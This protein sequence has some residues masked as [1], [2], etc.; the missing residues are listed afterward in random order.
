M[1]GNSRQLASNN[2]TRAIWSVILFK[3]FQPSEVVSHSL[4]QVFSMWGFLF[5]CLFFHFWEHLKG[6]VQIINGI[7]HSFCPS[8]GSPFILPIFTVKATTTRTFFISVEHFQT[9]RQAFFKNKV[10]LW[11]KASTTKRDRNQ[12]RKGVSAPYPSHLQCNKQWHGETVRK[13]PPVQVKFARRNRN[14]RLLT[15]IC[16]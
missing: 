15:T 8:Q 13:H 3:K 14:H 2:S 7:Y 1:H 16:N 12:Q 4:C 5:V 11:S 6:F 10:L 9:R